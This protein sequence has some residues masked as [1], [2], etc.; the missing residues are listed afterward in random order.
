[1]YALDELSADGIVL[2]GSTEGKFLGDAQFDELM[3]ELDRREAVVFVHPNLHKTSTELDLTT[4]GYLVEFLCGT[5]RAAT[6]LILSGTMERHPR[7][8]WILAHAGGFLPYIAWRLSLAN[9]MPSYKLAAPE[10]VLHYVRRFYYDTALSP[11][12]YAL[13]AL[14]EMVDADHI[15]F[16]SDYGVRIPGARSYVLR[17]L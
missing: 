16:G 17:D 15:L 8:R 13:S 2:L 9:E 3:A 1:M 14:R 7:I 5:T 10:G 6:N 12:P 11:A 4:P